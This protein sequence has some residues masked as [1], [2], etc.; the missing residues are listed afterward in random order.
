MAPKLQISG[1][2]TCLVRCTW[3]HLTWSANIFINLMTMNG[4]CNDG[5]TDGRSHHHN[6]D[7]FHPSR[8]RHNNYGLSASMTISMANIWCQSVSR[9]T[10]YSFIY[11]Q[12]SSSSNVAWW[13][14]SSSSSARWSTCIWRFRSKFVFLFGLGISILECCLRCVNVDMGTD[15]GMDGC[16]LA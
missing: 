5:R 13:R 10:H 1:S 2:E 16:S 8:R 7:D 15:L 9:F 3:K 4:D 6:D 14:S 12:T 11:S